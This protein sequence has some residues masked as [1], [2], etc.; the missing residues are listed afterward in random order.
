MKTALLPYYYP[1][2]LYLSIIWLPQLCNFEFCKETQKG[3]TYTLDGLILGRGEAYI[4]GAYIWN[5]IFVG[6]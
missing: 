2:Y 6:K 5:N 1:I 3:C 4:R